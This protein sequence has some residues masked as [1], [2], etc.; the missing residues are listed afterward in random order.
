[1]GGNEGGRKEILKSPNKHYE[2]VD[3]QPRKEGFLN[4]PR[5][6]TTAS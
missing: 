6:G 4:D 2:S 1:M 3:S 5:Q